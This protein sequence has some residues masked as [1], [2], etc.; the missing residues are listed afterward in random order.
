MRIVDILM[1]F[2]G[3]LLNIAIVATVARPGP[4]RDDRRAVRQRLGR[5]RARRARPGARAARARLRRRGGRARRLAIAASCCATCPEPHGPG[6]RADDVRLRQRDPRSRRRCRSSASARRS[7]TP[8]ARCSIRA[9]RFCGAT[10]FTHYAL[11]PG[12]AITWVVLGANLLGDG[13]RDRFDPRQRGRSAD[14]AARAR[15]PRSPTSSPAS[16]ARSQVTGVTWPVIVTRVDGEL[17]AC[18]GVCPHED[19]ALCRRRSDGTCSRARA[20]A[21]SSI[22]A[23][24]AARTIATLELRRYPITLVGDEVWVDLL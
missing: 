21:T 24:A 12:L 3:I 17:I 18:P 2:P 8:G 7:T 11:I 5:L 1:A 22:C 15:L 9:R 23:P 16:C 6:A 4:R 10:G 20:T 13:L 14:G 19:V